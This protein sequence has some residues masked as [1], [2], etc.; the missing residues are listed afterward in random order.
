MIFEEIRFFWRLIRKIAMIFI[1]FLLFFGIIEIARAYQTLSEVHPSLAY[2]FIGALFGAFFAL[3]WYFIRGIKK[4]PRVLNVPNDKNPK[5]FGK[6]LVKYISRM[7]IN[8]LL[9]AEHLEKLAQ[10]REK[11]KLQLKKRK[12]IEELK[13]LIA[14]TE[15]EAVLPIL[16]VLDKHAEL[17]VRNGVRDIML[18][19]T[20][21]PY[22][23][24]DLMIVLYR[25]LA[26]VQS[27]AKTYNAR[28]RLKEM[29]RIVYDTIRVVATV[30][31]V[32]LGGKMINN[33]GKGL[34]G[35]IP[36]LSRIVDD[37][38]EG[39][40]A[41]LLTSITGHAAKQRCRAYKRWD[42]DEAKKQLADHLKTFTGDVGKIFFTDIIPNMKIPGGIAIDKFKEVKDSLAKNFSETMNM[43]G[44]FLR[45]K[46]KS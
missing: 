16:K 34:P 8:P 40:A 42:Y 33:I 4:Y 20:L 45:H 15:Q 27:V 25:N 13:E 36:G 46:G 43:V 19:V 9:E 21:S 39:L 32:N 38:T 18:A 30:N 37:C 7:E 24:V 26:I 29:T 23:S 6:Y 35:M 11:L 41:G 3:I 28:P 1:I 12:E 17:K 31:F 14:E 2:L 44:S 5:K 22:R 10:Y